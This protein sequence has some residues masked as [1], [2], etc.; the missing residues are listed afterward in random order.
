MT[1]DRK[2][3]HVD[4]CL[5]EDVSAAVNYWDDV[6][7]VHESLPELALGEIDT[8]VELFGKT[9][10]A[11]LVI[12]AMTGGFKTDKYD[13]E[14]IN[15]NLAA[16]AAAV[17]VGMGVGSMRVAVVNKELERTFSV[18]KDHD[19]PLVIGN[20]GAPQLVK[21]HDGGAPLTLEDI[22]A[23][24]EL[25]GA[26][27]MAVHL[28]YLQEVAMVDGDLNA[29]GCLEMLKTISGDVPILAK[30]TGAGISRDT[31]LKLKEAGAAGLDIGGLGGTSFSA[32]ESH[33]AGRHGDKVHQRVGEVFW[34]WGIPA[35]ISVLEANVG[36]PMIATGGIRTGY[37]MTRALVLGANSAGMA[38]RLLGAAVD[39]SDAVTELLEQIILE[40]KS[41]MFLTGSGSVADLAKKN[42]I[43]TGTTLH[44]YQQRKEQLGG[45]L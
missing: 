26:D 30:E 45:Q 35:P 39:S 33:R 34:N 3:D 10:K 40:L 15:G 13:A 19:V 11:P 14:Q 5:T 37:D 31:A 7:L 38:G 6:Q 16:G 43:L 22:Q 32:V 17:G 24:V 42:Y 21:Q 28:N 12:A 8:G 36:L 20:I 9:L 44:W 27:I 29:V 25:I 1:K 18:V 23:A 2:A 41:A 4:I